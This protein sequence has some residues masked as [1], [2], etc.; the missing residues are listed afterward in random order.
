MVYTML[1]IDTTK[2]S[3]IIVVIEKDNLR[4]M[5]EADPAS[6]ESVN[7]GGVMEVPKYPQALSLLIAYENDDDELYKRVRAGDMMDLLRW[8]ERGRK[9]IQ[10]EDGKENAFTIPMR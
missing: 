4:R 9:F 5:R 1:N 10:G 7:R 2:E 3:V 8:L 6:L